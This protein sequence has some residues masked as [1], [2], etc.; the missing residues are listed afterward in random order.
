[1]AATLLRDKI[2]NAFTNIG[3]TNGTKF[4]ATWEPK[5]K[6]SNAATVE[7]F[8]KE[9]AAYEYHV[10]TQLE[11]EAKARRELAKLNLGKYGVCHEIAPGTNQVT[12]QS[13]NLVCTVKRN[14]D[15]TQLDK[16]ALS[17]NLR[18]KGWTEKDVA[19]LLEESSKSKSGAVTITVALVQP[20]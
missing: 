17:N 12:Y 19:A 14:V 5:G 16:T 4:P 3:N 15:G 10:A 8:E 7:W 13:P 1:M 20:G 9:K 18:R 11:A 2:A 6:L